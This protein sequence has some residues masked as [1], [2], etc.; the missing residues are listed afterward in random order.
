VISECVVPTSNNEYQFTGFEIAVMCMHPWSSS[1]V[2]TAHVFIVWNYLENVY[3]SVHI[4]V[5]RTLRCYRASSNII[6]QGGGLRL[7]SQKEDVHKVSTR[8]KKIKNT[9]KERIVQQAMIT[10]QYWSKDAFPR[11]SGLQAGQKKNDP[12]LPDILNSLQVVKA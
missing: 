11:C 4:Y 3:M 5:P 12:V 8:K 9:Q 6:Y 7:S 1:L 2:A 10:G